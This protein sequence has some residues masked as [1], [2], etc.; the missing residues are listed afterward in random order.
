MNRRSLLVPLLALLLALLVAGCQPDPLTP[1][2]GSDAAQP[3]EQVTP[4]ETE[5]TTRDPYDY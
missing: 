2:A 4:K 3:T 1:A 5:S